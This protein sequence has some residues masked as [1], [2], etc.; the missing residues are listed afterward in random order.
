MTQ[1]QESFNL[2]RRLAK[3]TFYR[4]LHGH[5]LDCVQSEETLTD[6]NLLE[7]KREGL[8]FFRVD[9]PTKHEEKE[10]GFD[11]EFWIGCNLSGW[12]R[13]AV[14]AKRMYLE[15]GKY[16]RLRHKHKG[17][18]KFQIEVLEDFAQSTGAIPLYCFYNAI[19]HAQLKG[20]WHCTYPPEL[21]QMGCTIVPLRIVKQAHKPR[22]PKSFKD[23]HKDSS[24][25]PWQCLLCPGVLNPKLAQHPNGFLPED[26]SY[27]KYERLPSH[28]TYFQET[29]IIEDLPSDLYTSELGGYPKRIMVID[30]GGKEF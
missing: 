2:L 5:E 26:G 15:S 16:E 30:T 29:G 4:M 18:T 13:Y 25:K 27:K 24:A 6:I 7:I 28:L 19:D 20:H 14:Q 3:D 1:Y 22:K 9:K 17:A 23:L 12:D 10:K 21:E 8:Y 11:W